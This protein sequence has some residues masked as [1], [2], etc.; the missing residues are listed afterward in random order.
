VVF[1]GVAG[2]S[3]AAFARA[4]EDARGDLRASELPAARSAFVSRAA[5]FVARASAFVERESVCASGCRGFLR[6]A[7]AVA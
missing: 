5:A 6:E 3:F 2:S 4:R 7:V 1:D